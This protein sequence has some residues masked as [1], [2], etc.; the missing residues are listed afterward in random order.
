MTGIRIGRSELLITDA[1]LLLLADIHSET[2]AV[3]GLRRVFEQGMLVEA[4]DRPDWRSFILQFHNLRT[5]NPIHMVAGQFV[6]VE[7][8][9]VANGR[10][11]TFVVSTAGEVAVKESE[12]E[13]LKIICRI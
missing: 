3:A 8:R 4:A 11:E 5:G 7:T 2:D 13:V 12:A 9:K 10:E 1:D 6:S